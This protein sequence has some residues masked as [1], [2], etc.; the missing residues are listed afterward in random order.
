MKYEKVVTINLGNYESIK[1]GVSE[2]ESFDECNKMIT[3][4]II[5]N[6]LPFDKQIRKAL[7]WGKYDG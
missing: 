4:E 1:L 5:K 7:S 3:D 6:K 2:C